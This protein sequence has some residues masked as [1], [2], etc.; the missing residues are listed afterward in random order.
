MLL[1][2]RVGRRLRP[3]LVFNV[4]AQARSIS[5]VFQAKERVRDTALLQKDCLARQ[6]R[7]RCSERRGRPSCRPARGRPRRPCRVGFGFRSPSKPARRGR[8]APP[9]ITLATTPIFSRPRAD[10]SESWRPRWPRRWSR[11]RSR[12]CAARQSCRRE[13]RARCAESVQ[14]PDRRARRTVRRC[15][16][17]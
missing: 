5:F 7:S 12:R 13:R 4:S 17:P 14:A 3:A 11:G 10:S 9:S 1:L 16:L 2:V 6:A 15:S 8:Q